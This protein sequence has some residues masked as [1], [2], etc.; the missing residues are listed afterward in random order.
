MLSSIDPISSSP[1][2]S[3]TTCSCFDDNIFLI[4]DNLGTIVFDGSI[5]PG[6][7]A[8]INVTAADISL[9][10]IGNCGNQ[11]FN[12]NC[13]NAL[14]IVIPTFLDDVLLELIDGKSTDDTLPLCLDGL[15][16]FPTA[17]PTNSPS[18]S[19]TN[20]PTNS[21]TNHRLMVQ[22]M[23]QQIHLLQIQFQLQQIHLQ[24]HQQMVQLIRQQMDQ[25]IHLH[26]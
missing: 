12:I 11:I 20:T 4:T 3:P 25:V 5:L 23:D 7:F 15:T 17:S 16:C 10:I 13:S 26:K 8:V 14:D 19:P 24:M 1:T 18:N 6:E 2:V 22:P 21:P 9:N